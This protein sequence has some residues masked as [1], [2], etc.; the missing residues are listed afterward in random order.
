MKLQR[1]FLQGTN[2]HT[3]LTLQINVMGPRNSTTR[4][5]T[6]AVTTEQAKSHYMLLATWS[7]HHSVKCSLFI[8]NQAAAMD[9]WAAAEKSVRRR[10]LGAP[11][12]D[13][14]SLCHPRGSFRLNHHSQES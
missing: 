12:P 6:R 9:G 5:Q 2:I 14:L 7:S 1:R 3:T 10:A 13:S 8:F 4:V 11:I